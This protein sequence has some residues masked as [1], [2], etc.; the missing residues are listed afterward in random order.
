MFGTALRTTALL[1]PDDFLGTCQGCTIPIME[2][3][4][5]QRIC[6]IHGDQT[7]GRNVTMEIAPAEGASVK[8]P[9]NSGTGAATQDEVIVE[10]DAQPSRLVDL[11]PAGG[12]PARNKLIKQ[13][14]EILQMMEEEK[15]NAE[16]GCKRVMLCCEALNA[17][18]EAILKL[19][20]KKV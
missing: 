6:V 8:K 14:E 3:R 17:I 4:Q 1:Y 13:V 2:S 15:I 16:L 18:D 11:V 20:N 7:K 10:P 9:R 5:G 19:P 12:F